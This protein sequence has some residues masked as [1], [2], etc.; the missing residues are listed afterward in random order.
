MERRLERACEGHTRRRR[1]PA[2]SGT[3]QAHSKRPRPMPYG[4]IPARRLRRALTF[5]YSGISLSYA[6]RAADRILPG[7]GSSESGNWPGRTCMEATW[8]H[9][10]DPLCSVCIS[11]VPSSV[12]PTSHGTF[13]NAESRTA[14]SSAFSSLTVHSP[15]C[16]A[17]LPYDLPPIM[18]MYSTCMGHAE[19]N[20]QE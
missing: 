11:I 6:S 8:S 14:S 9:P 3:G 7:S 2:C 5:S 15:R 4:S 20:L 17:N 18:A 19:P 12:R 1:G 13:R 10:Y 16:A